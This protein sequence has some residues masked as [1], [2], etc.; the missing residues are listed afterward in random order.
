MRIVSWNIRAGG[1][2]RVA[3]I[4]GQIARWAPDVVA[5]S[6]FRATPP[7]V[8]LAGALAGHGLLHQLSTAS[9]ALPRAN[10]LLIASRWPLARVSLAT[11]PAAE[12]GR[13]LLARIA[14]PCALT[15]GVMHVPNRVTGRKFPF[16]D[17]VLG[18][19]HTWRRGPALLVGD[20]N[21]GLIDLDEEVPAFIVE[22]DGWV[23]G[24]EAAGWADAF[25]LLRGGE[26]A[27]T[28]YSPNGGNGFR[29]DQAFVNRALR[30]RLSEAR[31]EWGAIPGRRR[32]RARR[33]VLSDHA[34]LVLDL[35]AAVPRVRRP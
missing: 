25:R 32:R 6:E 9:A 18:V 12:S 19:A 17:A 3:G 20:T 31:H 7:S 1:G 33:D 28:W 11:A 35:D 29:I 30:P 8:E 15:L 24:L 2:R 26:R 4:A 23:R 16:L 13:W 34:A 10:S 14:G 27:Y 5:L 21:S 22:E